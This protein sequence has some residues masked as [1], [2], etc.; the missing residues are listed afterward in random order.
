[1]N[2]CLLACQNCS[3]CLEEKKPGG[4]GKK[5][6]TEPIEANKLPQLL[7]EIEYFWSNIEQVNS[8]IL[9]GPGIIDCVRF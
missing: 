3:S 4:K 6:R 5:E 7:R 2:F 8:D 9:L 1:M